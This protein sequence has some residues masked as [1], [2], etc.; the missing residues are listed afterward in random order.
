M[1]MVNQK[2]EEL[3]D[4]ILRDFSIEDREKL[5]ELLERIG[6]VVSE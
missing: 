1:E 6:H 4:L 3:N 5:L 2:I